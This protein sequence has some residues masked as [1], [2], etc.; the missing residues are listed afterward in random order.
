[1]TRRRASQQQHCRQWSGQ[2]KRGSYSQQQ[3]GQQMAAVAAVKLFQWRQ[4]PQKAYQQQQ[5]AAVVAQLQT[6]YGFLLLLLQQ[7]IC[8]H[9]IKVSRALLAGRWWLR[10]C[11]SCCRWC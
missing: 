1:V 3:Q 11:R 7:R 10:C 8:H 4:I 2:A 9:P 5:S 6:A